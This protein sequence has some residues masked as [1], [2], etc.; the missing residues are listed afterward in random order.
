[1]SFTNMNYSIAKN[2]KFFMYRNN[3]TY[4][5]WFGPFHVILKIMECYVINS[6]SVDD[7]GTATAIR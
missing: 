5:Y 4:H 2:I 6:A 1:M 7:I 3:F